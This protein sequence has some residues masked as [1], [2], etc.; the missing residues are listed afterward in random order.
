MTKE[1]PAKHSGG[2]PFGDLLGLEFTETTAGTSCCT[3]ELCDR[4]MNPHGVV[5]GGVIYSMVDTGMGGALYTRLEPQQLCA[6]VEIKIHYFKAVSSGKMSCT[7]K[8]VHKGKR[9]AV[10]ESEVSCGE[11]L[12]AKALG[13]YSIFEVRSGLKSVAD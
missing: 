13:T 9:I 8:I 1:V 12:I 2:H 6:T 11:A 3:I 5:H 7:T 4:L 10:L